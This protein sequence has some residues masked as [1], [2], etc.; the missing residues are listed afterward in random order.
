MTNT[1]TASPRTRRVLAVELLALA[2]VAAVAVLLMVTLASRPVSETGRYEV[3]G[4]TLIVFSDTTARFEPLNR[5]TAVPVPPGVR[6]DLS[7][8][9]EDVLGCL[10]DL[11]YR[12]LPGGRLHSGPGHLQ[13]IPEDRA[14]CSTLV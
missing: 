3:P 4:G 1:A 9:A 11:G 5:V 10:A 13:V 12:P 2:A 6:L 8:E 7:N 14:M